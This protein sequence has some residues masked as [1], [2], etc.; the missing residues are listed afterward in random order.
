[1][2]SGSAFDPNSGMKSE[3]IL[4]LVSIIIVIAIVK[5]ARKKVVKHAEKKGKEE[6]QPFRVILKWYYIIVAIGFPFYLWFGHESQNDLWARSFLIGVPIG[7]SLG[8]IGGGWMDTL[9]SVF[10]AALVSSLVL[11][12]G[13]LIPVFNNNIDVIVNTI[14]S[15]LFIISAIVMFRSKGDLLRKQEKRQTNDYA[16]YMGEWESPFT[17]GNI[18][19]KKDWLTGDTQYIDKNTGNVVATG[20]KGFFDEETI[21]DNNGN[22]FKERKGTFGS[23]Y[24]DSHGNVAFKKEDG[25]FGDT[26][27]KDSKGNRIYEGEDNF[28]SDGKTFKKK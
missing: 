4:T 1:M 7:V 26:V 5:I 25:A 28:F 12:F 11:H 17:S 6:K 24:T 23:T 8:T 14:S 9:K 22:V 27:V 19:A 18:E 2:G 15:I 21:T 13:K 16:G 10:G 20:K 3:L